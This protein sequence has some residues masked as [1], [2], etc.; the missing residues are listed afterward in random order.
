MY[1]K[2]L[3]Q[4]DGEVFYPNVEFPEQL[5]RSL[6]MPLALFHRGRWKNIF[7]QMQIQGELETSG[8]TETL[9]IS[10]SKYANFVS[11]LIKISHSIQHLMF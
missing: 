7:W 5:T 1:S 8:S 11:I 2:F 6:T 9:L 10:I 3:Y 4:A